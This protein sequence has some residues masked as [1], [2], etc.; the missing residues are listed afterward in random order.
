MIAVPISTLLIEFQADSAANAPPP[1]SVRKAAVA[2]DATRS[3]AQAAI[4]EA[5][6]RG[7]CDGRGKALAEWTEQQLALARGDAQDRARQMQR[8]AAD[9]SRQFATGLDRIGTTIGDMLADLL[10]PVLAHSIQAAALAALRQNVQD[11][12]AGR[13]GLTVI[14]TG[15]EDLLKTL[16][17]ALVDTRHDI[18]FKL[19]EEPEVRVVIDQLLLETRIGDWIK[20]IEIAV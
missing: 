14:V 1:Q 12:L 16:R 11:C 10:Q 7:V 17:P 4:T 6:Q 18:Q 19:A 8:L 15:P 9:L 3:D 20:T 13:P 2:V 5:Y